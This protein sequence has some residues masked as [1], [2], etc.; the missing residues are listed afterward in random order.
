[1]SRAMVEKGVAEADLWEPLE[2]GYVQCKVCPHRCRIASGRRGV[3]GV[4][5]NREGKLFTLVYALAV[6]ANPYDPIEKKPFFHYRPGTRTFSIATLG[7][8]FRCDFC[9]NWEISQAPREGFGIQG[10]YL[11]PERIVRLA[12][13]NGCKTVA[14]TYTEPLIFLEYALDTGKLAHEAGLENLFVT[15]GFMTPETIDALTGLLD[16]A[17]VD[18]KGWDED[19]YRKIIKGRRDPVLQ[20]LK[21]MK[22]RGIW[23]EVTTLLVPGYSDKEDDLRQIA[24]FIRDE[25]GPET[26]WH[27]SRFYPQYRMLH[28]PPTP[29]STLRRGREIGLEEGLYYVYTG[30]LP[31]DEG[32]N[33]FCYR[34]G[35]LLV[36]RYG[37]SILRYEIRAGKCPECGAEIHGVGL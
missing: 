19:Y 5:E 28:I 11:P 9:Q 31:G 25:L 10:Q 2:D 27:V 15:N 30:N 6:S 12:V 7:C 14:Y 36:E 32:E 35:K 13:Q 23:V 22:E 1:M 29:P 3:C 20:S 26:P 34:C 16:A 33:T 17:N 24:R 4:R 8:N 21:M 37:F 18:L